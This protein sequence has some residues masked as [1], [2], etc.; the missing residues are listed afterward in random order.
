M[1]VPSAVALYTVAISQLLLTLDDKRIQL[2]ERLWRRPIEEIIRNRVA[3]LG[4][5]LDQA[6]AALA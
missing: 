3:F 6:E 5:L 1:E 2:E 4:F